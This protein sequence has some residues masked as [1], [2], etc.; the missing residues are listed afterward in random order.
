[1]T[2]PFAKPVLPLWLKL[3]YS[4]FVAVLVPYY[5]RVYGPTNFLY[6]C[7]MALLMTLVAVWRENALLVSMSAVGILL[8]QALWQIDFWGTCVGLP[9]TGMTG[10]MFDPNLSLFVR[11]LSF[12]HFWLPLLLLWLIGRLGYDPRAFLAWTPLACGVLLICFFVMPAPPPPAGNPNLPV[13]IN[14]VYGFSDQKPQGWLPPLGYLG[15][16][17][18][19]LPTCIFLPT[20]LLLK[21]LFRAPTASQFGSGRSEV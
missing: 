12:F 19:I 14:Y 5:L 15:A 1:M 7:D 8:P 10:Y 4:A 13:N 6:F 20:H 9:V 21:R 17:L 2:S 16:M 3:A 11:G 18:L